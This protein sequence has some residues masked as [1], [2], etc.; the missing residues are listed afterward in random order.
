M[1]GCVTL[2]QAT[3]HFLS[4]PHTDEEDYEPIEQLKTM[5]ITPLPAVID[6]AVKSVQVSASSIDY[7]IT[8]LIAKHSSL[9]LLVRPSHHQRILICVPRS[10]RWRLWESSLRCWPN[11]IRRS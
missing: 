7:T 10:R 2:T 9:P 6:L 11:K 8:S 4:L 3:L 1:V 5:F